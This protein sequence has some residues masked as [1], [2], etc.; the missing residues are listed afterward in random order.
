ML[1]LPP[2]K[3]VKKT[4]NLGSR[5]SRR[6]QKQQEDREAAIELAG[7]YSTEVVFWYVV[8]I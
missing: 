5:V 1:F 4:E 8:F 6:L 7:M 3:T 2:K